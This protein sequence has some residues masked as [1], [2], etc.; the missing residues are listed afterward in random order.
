MRTPQMREYPA[1]R[2]A[3]ENLTIKHE[4]HELLERLGTE[5]KLQ[6]LELARQLAR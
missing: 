2:A 6:V 4:L 5:E 3:L 1:L